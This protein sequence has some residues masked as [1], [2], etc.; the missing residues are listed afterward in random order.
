MKEKRLRSH[1]DVSGLCIELCL[2]AVVVANVALQRRFLERCSAGR[3]LTDHFLKS[4]I[5]VLGKLEMPL[6]A[7]PEWSR[8][9]LSRD[10]G[11]FVETP[12]AT[13]RRV[14]GDSEAERDT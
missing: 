7:L 11:V 3:D 9:C 12:A 5:S 2:A 14:E 4:K 10:F 6:S 13:S 8:A 1:D